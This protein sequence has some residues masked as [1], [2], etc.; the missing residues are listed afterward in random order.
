MGKITSD[1]S[2][3][4]FGFTI[5]IG[6]NLCTCRPTCKWLILTAIL[7]SKFMHENLT[8]VEKNFGFLT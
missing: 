3:S 6:K 4:Y 7:Q 5:I 8:A 1:C 2:S